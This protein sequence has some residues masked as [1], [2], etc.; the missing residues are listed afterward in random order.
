MAEDV[1]DGSI[2]ISSNSIAWWVVL[3]TVG[4]IAYLYLSSWT[5]VPSG[6][7]TGGPG[8]PFIWMFGAFPVMVACSVLNMIW[9]VRILVGRGKR[10]KPTVVWLLFMVAW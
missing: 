3:N 5:W 7:P 10:W 4:I 2:R 9:I 1:T 8:D 6:E